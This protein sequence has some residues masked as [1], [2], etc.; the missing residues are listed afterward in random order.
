MVGL[1]STQLLAVLLLV[2]SGTALMTAVGAVLAITAGNAL[3][4]AGDHGGLWPLVKQLTAPR[5]HTM[6]GQV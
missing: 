3:A 1:I 6:Y 4:L 5:P 2:A